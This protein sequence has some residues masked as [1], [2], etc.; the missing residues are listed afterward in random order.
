MRLS[1]ELEFWAVHCALYAAL[2][3]VAVAALAVRDRMRVR[4]AGMVCTALA[5]MACFLESVAYALSLVQA[6]IE[7]RTLAQWSVLG[8][9]S[10][11]AHCLAGASIGH[12]LAAGFGASR[13]ASHAAALTMAVQDLLLVWTQHASTD[14]G[15]QWIWAVAMLSVYV[16]ALMTMRI[17]AGRP[18]AVLAY[19]ATLVAAY[20]MI[21]YGSLELLS[22]AAADLHFYRSMYTAGRSL[23]LLV[24]PLVMAYW[25]DSVVPASDKKKE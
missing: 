7:D 9:A 15:A 1:L 10:V 5:A 4:G 13:A 2:A 3:L 8:K 20:V 6:A 23:Q 14:H 16:P 17:W 24:L 19:F 21:F 12:A 25:A 22:C 18:S 11:V